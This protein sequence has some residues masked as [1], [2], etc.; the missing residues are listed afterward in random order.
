MTNFSTLI[1]IIFTRSTPSFSCFHS[2]SFSLCDKVSQSSVK[3]KLFFISFRCHLGIK[4][5]NCCGFSICLFFS[6]SSQFLSLS[7]SLPP[8]FS[9]LHAQQV[10]SVQFVRQSKSVTV[11]FHCTFVHS[12]T[13]EGEKKMEGKKLKEQRERGGEER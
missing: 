6:L 2:L 5:V 8:F 7:L 3:K 13:G 11:E 10:F 4:L 9:L 1:R 12:V